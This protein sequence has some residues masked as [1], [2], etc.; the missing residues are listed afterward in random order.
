MIRLTSEI[1]DEENGA[2]V[3]ASNSDQ[4]TNCVLTLSLGQSKYRWRYT[5]F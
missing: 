1:T 3:S 4:R 5:E 2:R